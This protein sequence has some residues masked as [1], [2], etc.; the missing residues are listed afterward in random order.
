MKSFKRFFIP[1]LLSLICLP[2]VSLA[3]DPMLFIY[4][5]HWPQQGNAFHNSISFSGEYNAG[6]DAVTNSFLNSMYKGGFL[7]S[8]TK[9]DQENRLLPSN[10]IG[11]YASYAM[12]YSWRGTSD[13]AKWEFMIAY[14]DRQSFSGKFSADAF[15][16]AFEGNRPFLGKTATIDN[17]HL[18]NMH[19][20]QLQFEAKYFSPDKRSD[21]TFGFSI[22]NGQQLQEINIRKGSVFTQSDG[23]AIDVASSATY[24]RSDTSSTTLGARN[25]SGSCFNFRFNTYLGDSSA[26]YHSQ[27]SFMVQDLGFIHW[28]NKSD[29]FSVDT[30]AHYTGVDASNVLV[31]GGHLTGV[32]NSDSIIHPPQHGQIIAFLP[33]GIRFRYTLITPY[34]WWGGIDARAWSYGDAMPHLTMFAG[35]HTKDFHFNVSGGAAYGGYARLQFPLQVGWESCNYFSLIVG[36]TNVAGYIAPKQTHG[37]GL[38]M[39]LSFAF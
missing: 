4:R 22:L 38:F 39:N 21:A 11:I 27:V 18:T 19:W 14:R 35:W 29:I 3:Q 36:T 20:Q 1:C 25:G 5:P 37:Q 8:T 31:N 24:F 2:M 34:S 23:T 16:L 12:A 9:A 26:H 13:S 28:N 30:N 17:T 32:P 10:R 6:S 33:L 15:K 7:D